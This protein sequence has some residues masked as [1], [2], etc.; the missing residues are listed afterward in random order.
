MLDTSALLTLIEDEA[1]ADQVQE[2]LEKAE[3]DKIILL[4]S[5]MSFMEDKSSL[6]RDILVLFFTAGSL[7]H[8]AYAPIP[9]L[10]SSRTHF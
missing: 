8:Q 7:F 10:S 4:V 5:F 2:L 3:R 6:L 9:F 1:G